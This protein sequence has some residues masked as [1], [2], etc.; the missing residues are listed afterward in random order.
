VHAQA[1]NLLRP[2]LSKG[3]LTSRLL[4]RR[5]EPR[6][7]GN[8]CDHGVGRI[9]QE[10]G[11]GAQLVNCARRRERMARQFT[12]VLSGE[13]ERLAGPANRLIEGCPRP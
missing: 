11:I 6:L 2:T 10:L 7:E 4:S 8:G 1:P 5:A 12:P 3:R 9:V 13:G